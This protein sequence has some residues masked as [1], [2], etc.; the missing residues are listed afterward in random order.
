MSHIRA[1]C[2]ILGHAVLSRWAHFIISVTHFI[3]SITHFIMSVTR[4]RVAT[5]RSPLDTRS[6]GGG[7]VCCRA[8]LGAP[9][10]WGGSLGEGGPEDL[11]EFV[12]VNAA[13][14]VGVRRSHE[15]GDRLEREVDAHRRA[16]R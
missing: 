5:K 9:E 14:A 8:H 15:A 4:Q 12:K 11:T 6:L 7:L 16:Q 1:W 2:P 3:M 13:V 10:G